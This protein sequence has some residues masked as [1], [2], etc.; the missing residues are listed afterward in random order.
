M[1]ISNTIEL[2]N[3]WKPEFNSQRACVCVCVCAVCVCVLCVHYLLYEEWERL[4]SVWVSLSAHLNANIS[5]D[6]VTLEKWANCFTHFHP[7][8]HLIYNINLITFVLSYFGNQEKQD[9][10]IGPIY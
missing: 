9:T 1:G 3:H 5:N 10:Q 4:I 2:I 8:S 7:I 6:Q